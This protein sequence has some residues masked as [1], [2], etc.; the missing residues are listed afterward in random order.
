MVVRPRLAR[1]TKPEDKKYKLTGGD[2]F[3]PVITAVDLCAGIVDDRG[4]GFFACED[5]LTACAVK[6]VVIPAGP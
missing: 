3:R 4:N 2:R 1:A 5:G 6:M